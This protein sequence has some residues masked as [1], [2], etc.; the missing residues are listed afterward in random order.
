MR[1]FRFRQRI[2]R[3]T[4]ESIINLQTVYG[5]NIHAAFSDERNLII[6]FCRLFGSN[7][8]YEI[9][10]KTNTTKSQFK[11]R[12]A[13]LFNIRCQQSLS[14]FVETNLVICFQ[15]IELQQA[16]F[17]RNFETSLCVFVDVVFHVFHSDNRRSDNKVNVCYTWNSVVVV[18]IIIAQIGEVLRTRTNFYTISK[19]AYH[20]VMANKRHA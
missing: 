12:E 18:Q 4:H 15:N 20:T 6:V 2:F 13:K 8:I 9:V 14:I 17:T 1:D 3:I 5:I 16:A 10:V 7:D 19:A 11:H